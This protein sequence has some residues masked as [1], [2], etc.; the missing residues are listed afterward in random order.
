MVTELSPQ[1]VG[2]IEN[3]VQAY[4]DFMTQEEREQYAW[5]A[6]IIDGEG[7]I[8]IGKKPRDWYIQYSL[9]LRVAMTAKTTIENIKAI[10]HVGSTHIGRHLQRNR[11]KPLHIWVCYDRQ[12]AAIL[13]KCLPFLVTKRPHALLAVGFSEARQVVTGKGISKEVSPNLKAKWERF[14]IALRQ[15]N[16]RREFAHYG[17]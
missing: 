12:A 4:W 17:D 14:Y 7:A 8:Y 15:L 1:V 16:A 13:R 9:T 6:G 10:T 5:L 3:Q 2:E 11:A